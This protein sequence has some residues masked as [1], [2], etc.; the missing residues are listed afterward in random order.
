MVAILISVLK[1]ISE[2]AI[3]NA[4]EAKS[5][6]VEHIQYNEVLRAGTEKLN[7]AIDQ[8]NKSEV[9]AAA[10]LAKS[11]SAEQIAL[12]AQMVANNTKSEFDQVVAE[13]GSNN[14]E[15]V[16]ARGGEVNLNSRLNK[17][18]AQLAQIEKYV[19]NEYSDIPVADAKQAFIQ[20]MNEKAKQLG[21]I[22]TNYVNAHGLEHVQQL[23][24]AK[25]TILLGI[26]AVEYDELARVWNKKTHTFNIEGI[27][28]REITL[29]TSVSGSALENHYHIFGGKTGT[30]GG[31]FLTHNLL[32]LV[33]A[34]NN[35]WFVGVVLKSANGDRYTAAKQLFDIATA[36]YNNN[37]MSRFGENLI[38]N[39]DFSDNL[40]TWTV[41]SGTPT[42]STTDYKSSPQSLNVNSNGTSSQVKKSVPL[43]NA[44]KYYVS[45]YVKC[46]RYVKGS[47]GVQVFR[48]GTEDVPIVKQSVTSG[49]ERVSAVFTSFIDSNGDVYVGGISGADLDGFVD[50]VMMIDLTKEF[51]S[52]NEPTKEE[53]DKFTWND[54]ISAEM[55]AAALMPIHNTFSYENYDIPRLFSKNENT[56][57]YQASITK[58]MTAMIMLEHV[59]DLNEK[60]EVVD[61]DIKLGSGPVFEAGDIMTMKDALYCMMLPSSNTMAE[62]VARVVGQRII[63]RQNLM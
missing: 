2:I 11:L 15:V 20:K 18:D 7:K 28:P 39:G 31:D 30:N 17:V 8:A 42:I 27:N 23:S 47:I 13:A 10:A 53:L 35:N 58:V 60:I 49:F 12:L 52:G 40:N 22:N 46:T 45:A 48:G 4:R 19:H 16:Q 37:S 34:P 33:K 14:P 29:T 50:D 62:A 6:P 24:S 63:G 21:M 51:G 43:I 56:Q 59:S 1:L 54:D 55:G 5:M 25:D 32:V 26:N 44:H 41:N 36:Q 3:F 61:T 9:D 38:A 57:W